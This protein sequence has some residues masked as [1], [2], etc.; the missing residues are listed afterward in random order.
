MGRSLGLSPI[1][2]VL[3][4]PVFLIALACASSP[5]VQDTAKPEIELAQLPSSEFTA[6]MRGAVSMAYQ[7]TIRNPS[8]EVL[9]LH[10]LEMKTVGRS[11][12]VLRDD[13]LSFDQRILPG[14]EVSVVFEMWAYP[15]PSRST[16]KQVWVRGTA[17]FESPSGNFNTVFSRSFLQPD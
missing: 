11:P 9:T 7:M 6:E 13:T 1:L 8:A 2:V 5:A 17:T 12:Y 15:E 14:E 4:G 10:A 3:I 16:G